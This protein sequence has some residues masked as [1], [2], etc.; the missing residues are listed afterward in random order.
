MK[1][2]I[3]TI[4]LSF[5]FVNVFAQSMKQVSETRKKEMITKISRISSS[6]K[7]MQCDF[8][9]VKT[10]PMLNNK[11]VSKGKMYYK[12]S[13]LLRWEYLSPYTYIFIMNGN[14]V[15]IKSAKKKSVIDVNK[16]RVFQEITKMI[17]NSVTGKCLVNS[18]DF[19]V[20]MFEKGDVWLA[21]LTPIKKQMKQMFQT[22]TIYFNEDK[23]M[24]TNI[25]MVEKKGDKTTISLKNAKINKPLNENVFSLD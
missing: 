17:M 1:K 19:K 14:N 8:I 9:Q 16:N 7:T 22:I 18:A 20:Q 21:K 4:I 3:V 5:V 11:M 15:Y 12:N 25:E 2:I 13:S 24:V 10:L 23:S 6:I